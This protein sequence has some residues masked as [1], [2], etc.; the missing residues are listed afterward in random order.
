MK[1]IKTSGVFVV[2]LL[3]IFAG[4]ARAQEAIVVNVPF[5]FLVRGEEM[6]AGKYLIT[7]DAGILSIRGTDNRSNAF[8]LTLPADGRDPVGDEPAVVFVHYENQH[9]L[10]QIWEPDGE[11]LALPHAAVT[12]THDRAE[13][14]S[15]SSVVLS[16]HDLGG[17]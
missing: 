11:G 3:G 14:Q 1:T 16:G 2:A 5:P 9:L 4:T 13:A 15:Q 10:S 8:A 7:A 17:K 12:L 6:S